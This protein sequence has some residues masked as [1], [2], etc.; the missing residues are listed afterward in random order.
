MLK[1]TQQN[2]NKI[3]SV[4]IGGGRQNE[5]NEDNRI[6]IVSAVPAVENPINVRSV[7]ISAVQS[8]AAVGQ[9]WRGME[10]PDDQAEAH[11]E[12]LN[13]NTEIINQVT[14][15]HKKIKELEKSL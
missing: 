6:A 8:S 9:V 15:A 12:A 11:E 3:E 7:A 13:Q 14:A 1:R 10:I 2:K 5:N 4:N